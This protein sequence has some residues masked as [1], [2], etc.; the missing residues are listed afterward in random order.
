MTSVEPVRPTSIE[1]PIRRLEAYLAEDAKRVDEAREKLVDIGDALT[2]LRARMH[3]IDLG[4]D[5]GV[6][7]LDQ[8]IAAPIIDRLAGT[9]ERVDNAMTAIEVG[10]GAEEANSRH[11]R[12][13]ALAGQQQRTLVHPKVLAD[14]AAAADLAARRAAGQQ[15]R[16]ARD[17]GSE[18]VVLVE[19]AAITLAEWGNAEGPYVL[20][21][22][23][24]LVG[25]FAAWFESMWSVAPEVEA[26]DEDTDAALIRLLTLGAK[27][28]LI[29]R[30]LRIGLRTVRR[31][32]AGLM[33]RYGVSTRFQLGVALERDG[34]L[35]R[36]PR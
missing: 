19:E 8:A 14:E 4:D 32:V 23:T 33:D 20:I 30:T 29:A 27:D 31:R 6:Q 22:N 16:V 15:Q 25:C 7:V 17:L 36:S 3:N 35:A 5:P 18:F 26:P 9:V 13:R 34:R 10:A 21:R 1:D 12:D 24:A 2:T 11:E 28:E